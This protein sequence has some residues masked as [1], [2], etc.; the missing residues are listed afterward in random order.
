MGGLASGATIV[1]APFGLDMARAVAMKHV[2]KYV[3]RPGRYREVGVAGDG[4]LLEA[5]ETEHSWRA[6]GGGEAIYRDGRP[7]GRA[8]TVGVGKLV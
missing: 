3:G 7:K 4:V 1:A 5:T 2:T 8:H 6:S